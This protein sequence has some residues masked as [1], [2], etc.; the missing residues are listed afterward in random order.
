MPTVAHLIKGKIFNTWKSNTRYRQYSK[1]R[2]ALIQNCFIAKPAFANHLMEINKVTF[3]LQQKKC[4]SEFLIT[5]N[6]NWE[7]EEF[8]GDQ[9]RARTEAS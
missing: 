9:K 6:K 7:I 5:T 8:K 1:T 3:D 4:I 2:A